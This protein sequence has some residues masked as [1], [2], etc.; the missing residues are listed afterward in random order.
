MIFYIVIILV[1]A[2]GCSG[3]RIVYAPT[4]Q[5]CSSDLNSPT[6]FDTFYTTSDLDD[7][8]CHGIHEYFKATLNYDDTNTAFYTNITED[9]QNTVC[10]IYSQETCSNILIMHGVLNPNNFNIQEVDYLCGTTVE[11]YQQY[12][13]ASVDVVPLEISNYPIIGGLMCTA[14]NSY[15]AGNTHGFI[16]SSNGDSNSFCPAIPPCPACPACPPCP[17][18]PTEPAVVCPVCPVCPAC[19]TPLTTPSTTPAPSQGKCIGC[20]GALSCIVGCV[21]EVGPTIVGILGAL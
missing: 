18:C 21:E 5:L 7:Q 3:Q 12:Q 4:C 15:C 9:G 2:L 8:F 13:L 20:K 11:N 17:S 10:A 16:S 6:E 1:F 19:P 14:N